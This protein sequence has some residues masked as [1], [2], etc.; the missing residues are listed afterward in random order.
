MKIDFET[1]MQLPVPVGFERLYM[2]REGRDRHGIASVGA[3]LYSDEPL[4]IIV[5][6]STSQM[7]DTIVFDEPLGLNNGEAKRCFMVGP[8][9]TVF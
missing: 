1:H 2:V 7:A 8:G 4:R 5:H 9:C 3:A 6:L